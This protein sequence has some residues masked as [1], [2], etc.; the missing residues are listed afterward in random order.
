MTKKFD[1]K[2]TLVLSA[3]CA[4]IVALLAVVNMI[5]APVI[6]AQQNAAANAAL[7]EVLPEGKNFEELDLGT[8]TLPTSIQKAWKADGGYVIQSVV[9]G[10]KDGLT[11][12]CGIDSEG[13][14]AG[15]KYIQ[16]NETLGAENGLGDRFVGHTKDTITLDIVAGSTAK[17]TT[18][19]Y[20]KAIEDSLTAAV[21]LGGGT[22]DL[23]TPEQILQDNCNAALGTEG[24]SFTKWF[25]V[26]LIE[27]VDA[28]YEAADKSGRVYVFG[29][30]FVGVNANGEITTADAEQANKD[31]AATADAKISSITFTDVAI[32]ST[33]KKDKAEVVSIQLTNEGTYVFELL[34]YGYQYMFDYG[35]GT[36]IEIK[37][38]I[39]AEGKIVDVLTVSHKESKGYGDACANEEY[40]EQYRGQGND[41]IKETVNK[42][43]VDHHDDLISTDT[44]DIG[45]IASATYTTLGYQRAL[46]LAFSVFEL[47]SA[48]G[49]ND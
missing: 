3:I 33:V 13:K 28:V 16:S 21:I 10:Y 34:G 11:I 24:V 30:S 42:Y 12:M 39:D 4:L 46:K 14:I 35:D 43:P 22:A 7:L 32:P 25:A 9:T 1:L 47:L 17:L 19:A 26:T 20:Y 29:E 49:G 37:L 15:A 40:Y 45:A 8:Y 2:P 6:E 27:G 31:A 36:P 38:A 5:T 41:D 48:E 23:R 44:T 18:N